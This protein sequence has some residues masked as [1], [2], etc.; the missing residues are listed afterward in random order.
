LEKYSLTALAGFVA[1]CFL[2]AMTGALFRPGEWYERLKKPSWRP[3][4]RLFAPVWTVLYMMIAVS[5]WLVW[6]QTGFAGAAWPLAV[7]ALQLVLNA[8]WT[9]LFFGLH[10]PDLGFLDIVLVWLSI[11]ATIILF[12]P[13]HVGAALLLVPYLAWV[14]FATALNF[15]VWRLNPSMGSVMPPDTSNEAKV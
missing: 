9:P 10:R 5:G 13:I 7:Y 6:R 15:A 8:V 2:A 1:V 14:T 11:V 4:N 3:P 12:F